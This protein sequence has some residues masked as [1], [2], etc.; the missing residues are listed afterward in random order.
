MNKNNKVPIDLILEIVFNDF[1]SIF[2]LF[3]LLNFYNIQ[4]DN[5]VEEIRNYP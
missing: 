3:F 1:N 5:N 2:D 4:I